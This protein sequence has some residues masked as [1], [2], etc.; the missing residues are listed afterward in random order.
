MIEINDNYAFEADDL[1]YIL[2]RKT[3]KRRKE[4]GTWV[5]TDEETWTIDGYYATLQQLVKDVTRKELRSTKFKDFFSDSRL[6]EIIEYNNDISI[7]SSVCIDF[8][9]INNGKVLDYNMDWSTLT[10]TMKEV[11]E[12]D[13]TN[14][15]IY[16]DMDYINK[17]ILNKENAESSR[18]NKEK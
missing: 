8:F 9:L 14:I 15:A 3:Y 2:T 10:L 13:I 12:C 1:N 5:T 4:N 7:S 6:G 16:T 17:I 11:P 18:I